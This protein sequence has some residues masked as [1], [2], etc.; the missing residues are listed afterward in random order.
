VKPP[1][2]ILTLCQLYGVVA[3]GASTQSVTL[4]ATVV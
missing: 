1:A 3:S 4:A 2:T